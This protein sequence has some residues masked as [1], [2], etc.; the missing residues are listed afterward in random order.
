[1]WVQG[2]ELR[3]V[4]PRG[5]VWHGTGT[6]VENAAAGAAAGSMWVQATE[7]RYI[8]QDAKVYALQIQDIG[9]MGPSGAIGMVGVSAGAPSRLRYVDAQATPHVIAWHADFAHGDVAHADSGHVDVGHSDDHSDDHSDNHT[10]TWNHLDFIPPDITLCTGHTD[11]HTDGYSDDHS[12]VG[13]NDV[14]HGDAHTDAGHGDVPV[15]P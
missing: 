7:L 4:G 9:A 12:D 15:T 8:G 5:E 2:S 10:D 13:H 1:M 11:S 3:F 14:A 6:F